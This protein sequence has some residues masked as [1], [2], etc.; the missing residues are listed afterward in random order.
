[1]AAKGRPFVPRYYALKCSTTR[2][3][4]TSVHVD[5]YKHFR[6]FIAEKSNVKSDQICSIAHCEKLRV[7]GVGGSADTCGCL[8]CK[9]GRVDLS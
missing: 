3:I 8:K 2:G 6:H 1:M 7:E 4:F 5:S 9:E